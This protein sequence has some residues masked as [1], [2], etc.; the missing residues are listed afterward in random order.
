M[1]NNTFTKGNMRVAIP[2]CPPKPP[3]PHGHRPSRRR[4]QEFVDSKI[5]NE[6]YVIIRSNTNSRYKYNNLCFAL[7]IFRKH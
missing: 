5:A 1:P 7:R 6:S 4:E 2:G 3:I